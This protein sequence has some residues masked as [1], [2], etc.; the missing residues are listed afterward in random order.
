MPRKRRGRG[1]N[2]PTQAGLIG[3]VDNSIP[4]RPSIRETFA[5][6]KAPKPPSEELAVVSYT[7]TENYLT[8]RHPFD[9]SKGK[10][11]LKYA[12]YARHPIVQ[13]ALDRIMSGVFWPE[14]GLSPVNDYTKN[15]DFEA[16]DQQITA[17]IEQLFAGLKNETF[18]NVLKSLLRNAMIYGYSVAEMTWDKD[19]EGKWTLQS[20]KPKPSWNFSFEVE[21][22]DEL[23]TLIYEGDG[24]RIEGEDI[25]NF[26]IGV[27]PY[28]EHG[29]YFGTSVINAVSYEIDQ[30]EALKRLRLQGSSQS[31]KRKMVIHYLP[32]EKS[33]TELS[34]QTAQLKA[35]ASDAD[36]IQLPATTDAD[37]KLIEQYK[38]HILE[39]QPSHTAL[40][41]ITLA[42]DGLTLD[43]KRGLGIPD[44]IGSTSV[45]VSSF[46]KDSSVEY[47]IFAATIG[48]VV[49]WVEDLVNRQIIP[50]IL[51]YDFPALPAGYKAPVWKVAEKE[52]KYQKEIVEY[53]A[54]A[55]DAG[56]VDATEPLVQEQMRNNLGLPPAPKAQPG[57]KPQLSVVGEERASA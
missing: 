27:W 19:A 46:A 17:R 36:M 7:R 52:E 41:Q 12:E 51:K 32:R 57:I 53:Y 48:G 20:I 8:G 6:V 21:G 2:N 33:N 56:I 31:V 23:K 25:S 3:R 29:N 28:L 11:A 43:I 30:L 1:A 16:L 47:D 55:I 49:Q 24:Q 35:F 45:S 40:E 14:M 54:G 5:K 34:K 37:G 9:I 50:A 38:I 18:I 26:V 39:D 13:D 22:N 10:D 42:I 4:G 15:P 44:N